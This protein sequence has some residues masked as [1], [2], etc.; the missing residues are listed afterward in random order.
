M[1]Q[2][3]AQVIPQPGLNEKFLFEPF[4]NDDTHDDT[5]RV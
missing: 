4:E 5:P 3:I 1:T 2:V